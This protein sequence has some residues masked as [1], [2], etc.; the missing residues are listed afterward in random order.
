MVQRFSNIE[1][2]RMAQE[3]KNIPKRLH[4]DQKI[5][6][7]FGQVPLITD[8]G[9]CAPCS[10]FGKCMTII[11]T[12]NQSIGLKQTQKTRWHD[13]DKINEKLQKVKDFEDD[14]FERAKA[15]SAKGN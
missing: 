1:R 8:S 4:H 10:Y 5:P 14:N 2:K 7:C 11:N 12:K 13:D 6:K 3:D 15:L 9:K